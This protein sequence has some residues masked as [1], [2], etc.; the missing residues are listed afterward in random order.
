MDGAMDI[1]L[2]ASFWRKIGNACFPNKQDCNK[3]V[4]PTGLIP[5]WMTV[6]QAYNTFS[7]ELI[8]AGFD[9]ELQTTLDDDK[10]HAQ[11][12]KYAAGLKCI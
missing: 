11:G 8:L 6:E 1:K 12:N 10:L 9:G 7:L 3:S 4:T 5:L 2:Y